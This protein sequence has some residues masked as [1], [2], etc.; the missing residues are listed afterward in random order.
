MDSKLLTYTQ[1]PYTSA[2]FD[3][4]WEAWWSAVSQGGHIGNFTLLFTPKMSPLSSPLRRKEKGRG[5]KEWIEW[6][7][8]SSWMRMAY[9]CRYGSLKCSGVAMATHTQKVRPNMVTGS[10]ECD[11]CERGTQ[12]EEFS[13]QNESMKRASEVSLRENRRRNVCCWKCSL[14]FSV[15]KAG[16]DVTWRSTLDT[17]LLHIRFTQK[18]QL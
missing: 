16:Q 17:C 10:V 11:I 18:K 4:V 14:N 3:I 2:G 9:L 5:V 1:I 6:E 12:R 7:R 13:L 8:P 15:S